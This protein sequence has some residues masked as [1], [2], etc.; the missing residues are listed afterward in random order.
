MTETS[1]TATFCFR[2][3]N[4]QP[5]NQNVKWLARVAIVFIVITAG[6]EARALQSKKIARIGILGQSDPSWAA[7]QADAF[8]QELHN[9]GYIERQ[10]VVFE[11]RYAEGKLDR[12]PGLADE[13][14]RMKV[15]IIVAS[16]TPG[17][18]AAK[19]ATK[20]IPIVFHAINDPVETGVVSS[21][22]RPG[23]NITG[24]TM[25]GAELYGKRLELIKETIPKLSRAAFLL[26]PNSPAGQLNLNEILAAARALKLQIDSFEVRT[27][28]DIA[29]AF[30]AATRAKSAAMLI[31][32]IPPI[33][34]HSKRII[35][36]AV[37]HRIPVIYPQRQWADSGGLM[38]YGANVVDSY[39]QLAI[40]VDK[41]FK[42]ANPA[43]LP[44]ERARKLELI[45]NLRAAK[46]ISLTIP[47]NVLVRADRVIR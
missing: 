11:R 42:G 44:V 29:P 33:S 22:A 43:E 46:Q 8:H 36:L 18:L 4:Q 9:L 7:P 38:S 2:A 34:T 30:G 3:V 32:Q 47:P 10:N 35:D 28:E 31:T 25:G 12:L 37:K 26:N 39:R 15:D 13:L 1:L 17:V 6:V 20:Q 45:I 27:P 5:T 24:V 14:V 23:G 41:I 16:S 40:Y 19:N 21:L